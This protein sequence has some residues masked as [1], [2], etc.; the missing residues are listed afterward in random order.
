MS[1]QEEIVQ[2]T[3]GLDVAPIADVLNAGENKNRDS[4]KGS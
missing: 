2:E 4:G 3:H 1:A